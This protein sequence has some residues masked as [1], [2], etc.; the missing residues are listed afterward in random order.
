[1]EPHPTALHQTAL[2]PMV[3]QLMAQPM[4]PPMVQL[5][6]QLMVQ[7]FRLNNKYKA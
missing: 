7:N 2:Q 6:A 3:L 1:M 5:I 4:A